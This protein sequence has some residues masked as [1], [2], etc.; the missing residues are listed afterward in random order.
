VNQEGS[1]GLEHQ[2]PHGF[3][4]ARGQTTGVEHFAAG[5]DQSHSRAIVLS[6]S[7]TSREPVLGDATLWRPDPR[8]D[9][10]RSPLDL[11]LPLLRKPPPGPIG[12]QGEGER[13]ERAKET[14]AEEP[15]HEPTV[16]SVL[17]RF[18]E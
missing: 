11:L 9:G 3:R 8:G 16:L 2:E 6:S 17:G 13:P 15:H 4:K 12:S 18:S 14:A 7:D 1:V 5:D 10:A